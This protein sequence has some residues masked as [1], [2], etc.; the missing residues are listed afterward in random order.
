MRRGQALTALVRLDDRAKPVVPDLLALTKSKDS[1]VRAAAL[2]A[3]WHVG[4]DE[5]RRLKG[6][7][8]LTW[9]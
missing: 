4:P 2:Y 8:Q 9:K 5:Y 6:H 7:G 3:L 1:G